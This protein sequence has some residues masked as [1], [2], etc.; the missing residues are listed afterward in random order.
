DA[1]ST[2]SQSCLRV[3]RVLELVQLLLELSYPV[4]ERLPRVALVEARYAPRFVVE[5]L[6]DASGPAPYAL[7]AHQVLRVR[8]PV[9]Q[10]TDRLAF[11]QAPGEQLRFGVGDVAHSYDL[12]VDHPGAPSASVP[13]AHSCVL[14]RFAQDET[15]VA[16]A[17]RYLHWDDA[18]EL[19][20]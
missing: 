18:V 20:R 12:T 16:D 11:V 17:D 5:R 10:E 1:P 7:R 9:G 14:R 8:G 4:E 13:P 15:L 3:L 2:V 19:H 6:D